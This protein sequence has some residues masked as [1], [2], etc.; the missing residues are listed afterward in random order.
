[1]GCAQ[2]TRRSAR[3]DRPGVSS[4]EASAPA[5]ATPIGASVAE[6]GAFTRGGWYLS[7]AV[8]TIPRATNW[9]TAVTDTLRQDLARARIER[10]LDP[11][12]LPDRGWLFVPTLW[13]LRP[14]ATPAETVRLFLRATVPRHDDALRFFEPLDGALAEAIDAYG[15]RVTGDRLADL[16]QVI[17]G[18]ALVAA[19]GR[20][21]R[22]VDPR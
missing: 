6:P 1:M 19:W 7:I 11:A 8:R 20:A 9:E 17:L 18:L 5:D 22:A 10:L 16:H 15:P 3:E 21:G 12:P 14:H 4:A 2:Q 13:A